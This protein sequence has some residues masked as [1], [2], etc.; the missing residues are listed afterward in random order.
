MKKV[1]CYTML[2][3]FVLLFGCSTD[4]I[5]KTLISIGK[6]VLQSSDEVI[7]PYVLLEEDNK[8][9]FMYSALSSYFAHGKYSIDSNKLIL[10]TEDEKFTYVFKINNKSISFIEDKSS[11]I[12]SYSGKAPV[13]DGDVFIKE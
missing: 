6:Y 1:I 5:D 13:I 2:L 3:I 8:F 11:E 7:A 12:P 10:T 9:V 4:T